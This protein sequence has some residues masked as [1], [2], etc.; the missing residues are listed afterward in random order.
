MQVY[1]RF[2]KGDLSVDAFVAPY[3]RA[4]ALYHQRE[5]KRQAAAQT[6]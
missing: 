1:E 4:R 3:V 2:L 6:L 5:L